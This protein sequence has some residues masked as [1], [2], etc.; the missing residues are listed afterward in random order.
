MLKRV[1][2]FIRTHMGRSL[3]SIYVD[4]RYMI[5]NLNYVLHFSLKRAKIRNV[6][7][8]IIQPGIYHPELADRF[9]TIIGAY[10]IAKKNNYEFKLIYKIPFRLEDYLKPNKINWIAD[11]KELDYSLIDT[12]MFN[13]SDWHGIRHL[14]RNKQY[15]CINYI[16]NDALERYVPNSKKIW[17]ELFNE[18]FTPTD[19][20]RKE[21]SKVEL[22]E[23]KYISIHL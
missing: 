16:G 19:I 3:W 23:K 10:Y 2:F 17:R 20:L 21:I 14:K 18:L 15:H 1:K 22:E 8:F 7:Y 11:F 12:R 9:K 13:Y 4:M 6:F 5:R